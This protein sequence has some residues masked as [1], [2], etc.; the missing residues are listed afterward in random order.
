MFFV[1]F[2]F[3]MD[4]GVGNRREKVGNAPADLEEL[5]QSVVVV[6][7]DV[8]VSG[9]VEDEKRSSGFGGAYELVRFNFN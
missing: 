7:C 2:V 3:Y 8:K 9:S 4:L 6:D 5:K 1:G